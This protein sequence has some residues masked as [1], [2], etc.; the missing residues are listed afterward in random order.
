[1]ET[2]TSKINTP[3]IFVIFGVTG[4]LAAKKIIPSLW[5]LFQQKRLPDKLSIIG[6]SR[7]GMGSAEFHA[8]LREILLKRGGENTDEK[9]ITDFFKFFTYHA[10]T[11][12]DEK[13]FHTLSQRI[14]ETE[15][16]WG[17]CTNKLFYLAVPPSSFSPILKNLATA[18]LNI[19]CGGDLGWSRVLVEKPFGVNLQTAS[20]LQALLALYFK[21]E[22]I[23]RIDHYFFKEIVQGIK[24]FRFSNN[25]FENIWDNTTIERIDI[26]LLESVGVEERGN[27]YDSVGTLRDVGQNHILAMLAALTMEY[28]ENATAHSIQKS[29]ANVLEFLAPWTDTTLQQNTYRAR[30]HGYTDIQ[31]V[32]PNSEVETYFALATHLLHSRWKGIPIFMEAGKR[33]SEA[34]KEMILTLKHPEKCFLCE[35]TKSHAPN[36]IV[37]RLEPNDEIVIH[38]WTKKPGFEQILEER[39]FSFFLY[40]KRVKMQYVEEYANILHATME[41]NQAFFISPDEITASWKFT[42]PIIDNWK[43]NIVPLMEYEP[44]TTPEAEN[45]REKN[46]TAHKEAK[47]VIGII[48]LG[49]MGANLARRLHEKQ[50]DVVGFNRTSDSTKNLVREGIIGAYSLQEF[51]NALPSPR[52]IWLMA[53]HQVVDTILANLTPLLQESDV[54]LDGGNSPYKS[55][56]QREKNL[57][58]KN[59]SFLDVGVSGGPEGARNGACLMIGGERALY[60]KYEPLFR[61][62]SVEKGYGYMGKS[63]AGHFVK[64]VHNGIEYGMMQAI[65]EGFEVM[66]KSPFSLNLHSIA[67]LYNH[68]SVIT[69]RLVQWLANA[70][71]KFSDELDTDECCS[72]KVSHSGEGQWTVDAAKEFG[73]PVAIIEGALEFRKQ[74]QENPSYTGKVVS[75]LRHEFGGHDT[76]DTTSH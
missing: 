62:L 9:N 6:F 23:Y 65:G 14:A 3:T 58:Q 67:E 68:G 30:Y 63:G 51:V 46:N 35:T 29:R 56:I 50:W 37:F 25:L 8:L 48:G 44:D 21:E 20:E 7:K 5:H 66:K 64:M 60:E 31:G 73:V 57:S 24:N 36:R 16:A 10:G 42:D 52:T 39:T 59:I 76:S 28:P 32:A 53:P 1:M 75:A 55:S 40:E 19:P 17:V 33:M 43:K 15:Q 11:F 4:D 72:G 26:R 70:Y 22:Q 12:E 71:E 47:G 2:P 49:K 61:D 13:A 54:I 18:K 74:S 38:F 69:S 34:R 27:F 45:L 41:G